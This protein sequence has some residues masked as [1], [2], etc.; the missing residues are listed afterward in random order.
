VIKPAAAVQQ[1]PL[2]SQQARLWFLSR[3]DPGN[4]SYALR[5]AVRVG[6]VLRIDVLQR[7]LDGVVSRHAALRTVFA[8]HGGVPVQIVHAGTTAAMRVVTLAE[9]PGRSSESLLHDAI[10]ADASDPFDLTRGPLLRT[11]VLRMSADQHVIVFAM[12]HIVSDGWSIRLDL[13]WCWH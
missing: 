1:A 11:L 8:E 10:A 2:S 6:G 4:P 12:H 13:P 9:A 5:A 3:L 7:A